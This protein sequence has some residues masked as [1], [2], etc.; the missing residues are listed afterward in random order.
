MIKIEPDKWKHFFI[1]IPLGSALEF[2]GWYWFPSQTMLFTGL[3]LVSLFVICYGFELFSKITGKGHY[4][5]M[6]VIAGMA[7]G[8]L[9]I[10][11]AW[12]FL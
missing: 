11:G 12:I 7:G 10:T 6:D 2:A 4:E 5:I 3:A 9:G 1:A 8:S